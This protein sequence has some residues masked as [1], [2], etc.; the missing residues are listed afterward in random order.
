[1]INPWTV[2]LVF[3]CLSQILCLFLTS[4]TSTNGHYVNAR[5]ADHLQKDTME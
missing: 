4:T 2:H 5:V 1:M 3:P